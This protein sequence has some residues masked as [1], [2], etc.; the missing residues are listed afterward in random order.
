LAA[1]RDRVVDGLLVGHAG[2]DR[3]G[4]PADG[5]DLLHDRC[6]ADP[7]EI[8]DRDREAVGSQPLG[9]ACAK[10]AS[11]AGDDGGTTGDGHGEP[12]SAG[13]IADY[14]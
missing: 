4:P 12:M 6:A 13:W 3:D 8:E 10:T 7:V 9:D 11:A 14:G 5:G 2:L 1:T